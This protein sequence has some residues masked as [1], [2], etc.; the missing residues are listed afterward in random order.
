MMS[1]NFF[2]LRVCKAESPS[3]T[4]LSGIRNASLTFKSANGILEQPRQGICSGSR[5]QEGCR[6]QQLG[7]RVFHAAVRNVE[8][9]LQVNHKNGTDHNDEDACCAQAEQNATQNRK[10]SGEL[11]QSDQITDS[12]WPV[13]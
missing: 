10:A 9:M 13:M 4:F 8:A 12:E 11:C 5:N 7:E 6:E 2:S 3:K 1:D